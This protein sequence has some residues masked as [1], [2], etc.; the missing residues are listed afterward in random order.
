VSDEEVRPVPPH[1]QKYWCSE[2]S[3]RV[4][5]PLAFTCQARDLPPLC[6]T[7]FRERHSGTC[8]FCGDDADLVLR[9]Y[10]FSSP[11]PFTDHRKEI[12]SSLPVCERCRSLFTHM[13]GLFR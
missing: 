9:T 1:E 3:R 10:R 5:K 6:E 12:V 2:C 11:V 7:H 4:F 13:H 8:G